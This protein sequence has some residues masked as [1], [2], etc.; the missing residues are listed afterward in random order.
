[1]NWL[2]ETTAGK[3][4]KSYIKTFVAVV[5]VLFLADGADVFSVDANDLKSW[6]A[7]GLA[8]TLPLIVTALDPTDNRFGKGAVAEA[9]VDEEFV[10]EDYSGE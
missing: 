7:S 1:M 6:L 8:A 9:P 3:A 5:I 10:V 2:N 4:V